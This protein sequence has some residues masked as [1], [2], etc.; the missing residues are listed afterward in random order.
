MPK[1]NQNK[2]KRYKPLRG[3]ENVKNIG[4]FKLKAQIVQPIRRDKN[5]QNTSFVVLTEVNVILF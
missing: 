5:T 1:K 3:F 2:T 4:D